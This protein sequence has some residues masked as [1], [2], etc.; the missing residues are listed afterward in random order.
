MNEYLVLAM[1][2]VMRKLALQNNVVRVVWASSIVV[3]DMGLRTNQ[4]NDLICCFT[5]LGTTLRNMPLQSFLWH[6]VGRVVRTADEVA[7]HPCGVEERRRN[8]T[9]KERMAIAAQKVPA[10]KSKAKTKCIYLA[11]PGQEESCL[12]P[13][14]V[15]NL[16]QVHS[17]CCLKLLSLHGKHNEPLR[18]QQFFLVDDRP[19]VRDPAIETM[20]KRASRWSASECVLLSKARLVSRQERSV[21]QT[22]T[23]C[24]RLHIDPF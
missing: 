19:H 12:L 7:L 20:V 5:H 1:C 2:A 13:E 10:N 8:E 18:G 14:V 4:R 15:V 6:L 24:N 3:T 9:R 23:A 17:L 11:G 21:H 16:R 22:H